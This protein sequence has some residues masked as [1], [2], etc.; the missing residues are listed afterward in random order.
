MSPKHKT[1][2]KKKLTPEQTQKVE[3]AIAEFQKRWGINFRDDAQTIIDRATERI[4]E[5]DADVKIRPAVRNQMF[6]MLI[7]KAP[8]KAINLRMKMHEKRGK[9][10]TGEQKTKIMAVAKEE[11][12]RASRIALSA[13]IK[14][15]GGRKK[16]VEDKGKRKKKGTSPKTAGVSVPKKKGKVS[17]GATIQELLSKAK[18]A[19]ENI[20]A[21]WQDYRNARK[22]IDGEYAKKLKLSQGKM[23]IKEGGKRIKGQLEQNPKYKREVD[24]LERNTIAKLNAQKKSRDSCLKTA[25]K[26]LGYNNTTYK[27]ITNAR[28]GGAIA[29]NGYGDRDLPVGVSGNIAINTIAISR[30][31]QI[32]KSKGAA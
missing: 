26:E 23:S 32:R 7:E 13:L 6:A 18:T 14:R 11:G 31:K 8:E 15:K 30:L 24:T 16:T 9:K 20:L 22:E 2:P 5:P 21:I 29:S 10:F 25:M 17:Q 3:S 12:W 19:N 28:E 1:A 27:Q 4:T